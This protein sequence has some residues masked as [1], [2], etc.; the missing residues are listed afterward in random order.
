LPNGFIGDIL[1]L[2]NTHMYIGLKFRERLYRATVQRSISR[3]DSICAWP[4]VRSRC[5]DKYRYGSLRWHNM[6]VISSLC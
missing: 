3:P 5:E 1:T 2:S 4:Y 6:N